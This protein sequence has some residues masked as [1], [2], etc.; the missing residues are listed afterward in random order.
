[1]SFNDLTFLWR[2]DL[3]VPSWTE[4]LTKISAISQAGGVKILNPSPVNRGSAEEIISGLEIS[5]SDKSVEA[6]VG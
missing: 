1:M 3:K 5:F 2:N 6:S 4:F